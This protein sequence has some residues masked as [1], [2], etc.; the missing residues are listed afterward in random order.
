[1]NCPICFTWFNSQEDLEAHMGYNHKK[2]LEQFAATTGESCVSR[3][4]K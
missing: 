3:R 2:T 4:D 1:M